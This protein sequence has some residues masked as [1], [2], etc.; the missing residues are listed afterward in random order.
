MQRGHYIRLWAVVVVSMLAGASVVHNI[1]K[2]DMVRLR[3]PPPPRVSLMR[4]ANIALLCLAR[5]AAD[6]RP[7]HERTRSQPSDLGRLPLTLLDPLGILASSNRTDT[8][9]DT[10]TV[11]LSRR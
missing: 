1:L 9:V 6:S 11:V 5:S 2:P 3:V 7:P 8:L 10:K 4:V